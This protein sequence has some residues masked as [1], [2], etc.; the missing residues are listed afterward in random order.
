MRSVDTGGQGG[1][2][3]H[4]GSG[5]CQRRERPR[6]VPLWA[7]EGA[8]MAPP[9][10][11]GLGSEANSASAR[12]QFSAPHHP[13]H[14]TLPTPPSHEWVYW[15]RRFRTRSELRSLEQTSPRIWQTLIGATGHQDQVVTASLDQTGWSGGYQS[16]E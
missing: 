12:F 2:G 13:T 9:E 8:K 1:A 14:P 16:Y 10:V 4:A 6:R 3:G 7:R 11:A 15:E 5:V